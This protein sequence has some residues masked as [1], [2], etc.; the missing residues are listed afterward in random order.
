MT[1]GEPA[2]KVR[3]SR[4]SRVSEMPEEVSPEGYCSPMGR[5]YERSSRQTQELFRKLYM[6]GLSAGDFEPVFR[7]L[8]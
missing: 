4:V 6:E 7:E 8:V 1:V 5:R 3:V 2:V